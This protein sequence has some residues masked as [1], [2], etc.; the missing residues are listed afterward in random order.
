MSIGVVRSIALELI[1]F[2]YATVTLLSS[3]LKLNHNLMVY[4][5]RTVILVL[6]IALFFRSRRIPR[7]PFWILIT[8]V[9]AITISILRVSF[10]LTLPYEPTS[11]FCIYFGLVVVPSILI[12]LDYL[13]SP[14]TPLK[15]RLGWLFILL[16][17]YYYLTMYDGGGRMMIA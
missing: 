17:G 7:K 12:V 14:F 4:T 16:T 3:I 10:R 15:L 5:F 11:F 8:L 1:I 9:A 13:R 6:S 2:G